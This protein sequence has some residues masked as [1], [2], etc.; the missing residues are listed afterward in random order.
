[1]RSDGNAQAFED[2]GG[3]GFERV[4]VVRR[5]LIFELG[6][7]GRVGGRFAHQSLLLGPGRRHQFVARHGHVED[8]VLVSK[9]AVL[10]E[11]TEPRPLHHGETPLGGLFV[12][13]EDLEKRRL[14]RPVGADESVA[15]ARD[16]L[17]RHV[18]EQSPRAVRLSEL[19]N[20]DHASPRKTACA[21][22][23]ARALIPFRPGGRHKKEHLRPK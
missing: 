2:R 21:F 11:N 12:A 20:F 7:P 10:P 8:G 5:N 18:L 1:M 19:R 16:E 9:K 22:V 23:R 14:A 3:A 17:E 13:R 4:A 15:F 6:E